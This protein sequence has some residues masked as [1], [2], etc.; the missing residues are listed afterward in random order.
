M[1]N[2]LMI[3]MSIAAIFVAMLLPPA[4]IVAVIM[5]VLL[6]VFAQPVVVAREAVRVPIPQSAPLRSLADLRA[7]PRR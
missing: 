3:I 1:R 5:L 6:C 7:P 2:L 4:A